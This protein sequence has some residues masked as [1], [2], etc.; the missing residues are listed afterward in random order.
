MHLYLDQMIR[1]ELSEILRHEG[2]DVIRASDIG[3]ERAE[4]DIILKHAIK[5]GRILITLD[6]HFGDWAILPLRSHPGV[7]RIRVNPTT[8]KNIADILIPFLKRCDKGKLK[9]NLVIVSSKR[10]RWIDTSQ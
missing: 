9:N 10:E 1:R 2:H 5:E 3:H 7:I 4:D 8:T 6:E